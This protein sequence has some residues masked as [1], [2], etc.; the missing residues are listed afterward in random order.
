MAPCPQVCQDHTM[1]D[2]MPAAVSTTSNEAI[3]VESTHGL[4]RVS[5][6]LEI[7]E[8][9]AYEMKRK[10]ICLKHYL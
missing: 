6:G 3:L 5:S 4:N 9:Q 7:N 10:Q 8:V 2:T 1:D